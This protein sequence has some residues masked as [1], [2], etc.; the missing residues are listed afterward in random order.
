MPPRKRPA[1]PG[2]DTARLGV[3]WHP[4]TFAAA[5]SAYL[6][7]LDNSPGSPDSVARWIDRAI[8]A[9][10]ALAPAR[11][12]AAAEGLPA[13]DRDDRP[14]ASRS[15]TV[16]A[17]T[18]AAMQAAILDDRKHGRTLNRSEFATQAVRIATETA[19]HRNGGTLPPA[20]A[21]LPN[22]PVR[23]ID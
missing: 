12:A 16:A 9:H 7:D 2:E 22:K 19:R 1:P 20:P 11:R 5:K 6:A 23:A 15:F 18:M 14:A 10:A 17:A 21:R 4:V 13:E 3:Y 8:A